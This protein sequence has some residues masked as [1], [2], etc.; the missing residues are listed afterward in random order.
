MEGIDSAFE[1][2]K[3]DSIEGKRPSPGRD[4][5]LAK[6]HQH[7]D[8]VYYPIGDNPTITQLKDKKLESPRKTKRN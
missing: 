7:D 1:I 4:K 6:K 8:F 3:P 2:L 5:N